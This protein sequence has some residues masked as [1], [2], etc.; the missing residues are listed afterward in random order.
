MQI[1]TQQSII[2]KTL[3]DRDTAFVAMLVKEKVVIKIQEKYI[4]DMEIK[5]NEIKRL[6]QKLQKKICIEPEYIST[7]YAA[8]FIGVDTSFLT[9]RQGKIFKLGIHFFKPQGETII[10]WK[11]KALSEW[12]TQ[13][14][15]DNLIDNELENLLRRS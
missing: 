7:K 12:L 5:N 8:L 6:N 9:K 11:I 4:S 3:S 10:R 15:S 13:Q 1:E 2:P 14:E